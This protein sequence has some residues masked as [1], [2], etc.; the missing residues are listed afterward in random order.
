MPTPTRGLKLFSVKGINIKLDPSWIV[1]FLLISWSLAQ[2]VFPRDYKGLSTV[3]YWI[4]GGSTAIIL[5]ISILLHELGHSLVG[6]RHGMRIRGITL[7]IFGGVA[8]LEDEPSS[9]K[10]ELLMALAGPIVSILL[11]GLFYAFELLG[12]E[13]NFPIPLVATAHYLWIVNL[14]IVVFN[15]VPGFPLDGG[16]V[17]RAIIWHFSKSVNKA[18]KIT[19]SIGSLFGMALIALGIFVLLQGGVISGIWYALIGFFLMQAAKLSYQ[20]L[21]VET[22]LHKLRVKDLMSSDPISVTPD[23]SIHSFVK[24]YCLKYRH[25][26]FPVVEGEELVGF[27]SLDIVTQIPQ[28][29]WDKHIVQEIMRKD[30][31]IVGIGPNEPADLA[32][33]QM[34]SNQLGRLI[35]FEEKKVLGILS[36]RDLSDFLQLESEAGSKS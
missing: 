7:F 17:L 24:N 9:P 11:A 1:I 16:R 25:H 23:L 32:L 30:F 12:L 34:T 26:G 36:L 27:L 4:M 18:T 35:V 22:T 5:F 2:G 20:R 13:S 15:L 8:E 33:R 3:T 6:I 14:A 28:E 29:E 19:S 31:A 10:I 21:T